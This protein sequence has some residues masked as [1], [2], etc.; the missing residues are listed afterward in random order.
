MEVGSWNSVGED[1]AT[2]VGSPVEHHAL[3]T[4][5]HTHTVP[6]PPTMP[7]CV[8]DTTFLQVPIRGLHGT[9][10]ELAQEIPT[11]CN[12]TLIFACLVSNIGST[13]TLTLILTLTSFYLDLTLPLPRTLPRTLPLTLP[14]SCHTLARRWLRLRSTRDG[15][16][17]RQRP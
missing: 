6:G 11:L 9:S 16:G 4:A 7:Y 10:G 3:A 15:P 2:P 1:F 8:A 13:L 5:S 12:P 14:L 17:P